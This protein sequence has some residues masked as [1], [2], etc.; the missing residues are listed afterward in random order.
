M[1]SLVLTLQLI[2]IPSVNSADGAAKIFSPVLVCNV[3]SA[4]KTT[5]FCPAVNAPQ[6]VASTALKVGFQPRK[7]MPSP[8]S[9]R[10][11]QLTIGI[12]S[13]VTAEPLTGNVPGCGRDAM[14]QPGARKLP[15]HRTSRVPMSMKN[16]RLSRTR[17]YGVNIS[18]WA[19]SVA[20]VTCCCV[21]I[22]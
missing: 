13:T 20:V 11:K 2:P 16:S 9:A 7:I 21:S 22:N 10:F 5:I 17:P 6:G 15:P 8:C 1:G 14:A 12:A 3:S 19:K 18:T 4:R